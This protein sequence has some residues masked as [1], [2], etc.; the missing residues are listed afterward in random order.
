MSE[1]KF[2]LGLGAQKAG[3]SWLHEVLS[4]H[5]C[6]DFGFAKEYHVFDAATIED[7]GDVWMKL[8]A[9]VSHNLSTARDPACYISEVARMEGVMSKAIY[10]LNFIQNP[11]SYFDYF[12]CLLR[13]EEIRVS[14]DMT[15]SYSGLSAQVLRFISE[16]FS[17]RGIDV[18]PVFVMRNPV[19]RL[20]SAVMMSFRRRGQIPNSS[21]LNDAMQRRHLSRHDLIRVR[22][23][24]VI[25][26][27]ECVFGPCNG[28][29]FVW[30]YEDLFNERSMMALG[31][32]IGLDLKY[33]DFD[34]SVNASH[35]EVSINEFQYRRFWRGY[36]PIIDAC[37]SKFGSVVDE[38]WRYDSGG[39]AKR[40]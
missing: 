19:W 18:V 31:E 33:P 8:R 39:V 4:S 11:A 36:Q 14:G 25:K 12:A 29:S 6:S 32:K 27:L 28:R 21:Q 5:P 22:Y 34:E 9:A 23:D 30:F 35:A 13:E 38:L 3:T 40:D 24:N 7:C 15:P 1:K 16:C 20:R 17:T 10:R 2:V 26:N 37:R